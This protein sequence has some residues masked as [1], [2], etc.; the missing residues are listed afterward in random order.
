MGDQQHETCIGLRAS[1]SDSVSEQ[2]EKRFRGREKV[3]RK[4]VASGMAESNG[5]LHET[6]QHV[7]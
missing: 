6:G 7:T 4:I 2:R 5:Q 1:A 3:E